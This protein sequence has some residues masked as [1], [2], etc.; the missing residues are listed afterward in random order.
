LNPNFKE[1]E[2]TE[3]KLICPHCGIQGH[4][5]KSHNNCLQNRKNSNFKEQ[6]TKIIC[7]SCGIS[8][9]KNKKHHEC[10]ENTKNKSKINFK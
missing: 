8:G 3:K 10:L 9:H 1:T 2:T 7:Q 5:K 6:E 4:T